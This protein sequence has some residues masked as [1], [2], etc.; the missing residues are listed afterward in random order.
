[1]LLTLSEE[2]AS[3]H[4]PLRR[5]DNKGGALRKA[6]DKYELKEGLPEDKKKDRR[7]HR[8]RQKPKSAAQDRKTGVPKQTNNKRM[9]VPGGVP[10][11]TQMCYPRS[12]TDPPSNFSEP[13]MKLH[14][15]R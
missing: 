13:L 11:S 1:M 9:E 10:P 4:P 12:S 15:S 7:R 3:A 5:K 8:Q 14:I 6:E 2:S